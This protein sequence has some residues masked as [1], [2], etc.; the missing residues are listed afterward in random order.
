MWYFF[1]LFYT[2]Y[3]FFCFVQWQLLRG[4]TNCGLEGWGVHMWLCLGL[5]SWHSHNSINGDESWS[6]SESN[7]SSAQFL[8]TSI[9]GEAPGRHSHSPSAPTSKLESISQKLPLD[10]AGV[11]AQFLTYGRTCLD[12]YRAKKLGIFPFL[13]VHIGDYLTTFEFF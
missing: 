3:F 2:N 5:D 1:F 11:H 10:G 7:I 6:T 13:Y 9:Q 8:T 4:L 12:G